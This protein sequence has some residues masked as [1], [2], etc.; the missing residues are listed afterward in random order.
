[1]ITKGDSDPKSLYK[2]Q[3]VH[4][5]FILKEEDGQRVVKSFLTKSNVNKD[6][7]GTYSCRPKGAGSG[8]DFSAMVVVV[9][10]EIQKL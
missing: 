5:F 7:D 6:D 4:C 8:K 3:S 9:I 2:F 1:M 10:G